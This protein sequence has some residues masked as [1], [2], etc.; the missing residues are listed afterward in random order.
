MMGL[1][2]KNITEL[3]LKSFYEMYNATG[4]SLYFGSELEFKKIV[5]ENNK[6]IS[7]NAR[8]SAANKR[9]KHVSD[10]T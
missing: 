4:V 2:H 6:K 5:S 9:S 3:I 10:L 8:V 1:N 7:I